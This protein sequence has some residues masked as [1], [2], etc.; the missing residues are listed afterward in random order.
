MDKRFAV[1]FEQIDQERIEVNASTAG[2]AEIEART[3][4]RQRNYPKV[5]EI[6]PL[7]GSREE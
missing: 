7:K 3:I 4:W 5:I 6:Q 1:F 2:Q